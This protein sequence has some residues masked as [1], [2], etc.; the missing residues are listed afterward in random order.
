M[1]SYRIK[2]NKTSERNMKISYKIL[3]LFYIYCVKFINYI[4]VTVKPLSI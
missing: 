1:K 3:Q 2:C 4:N